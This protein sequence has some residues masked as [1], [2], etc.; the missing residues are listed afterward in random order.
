MAYFCDVAVYGLPDLTLDLV[1]LARGFPELCP[2]PASR[3]D[4]SSIWME[5]LY[6]VT[7]L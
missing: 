1:L 6:D 7:P 2:I 4:H 5:A 3:S